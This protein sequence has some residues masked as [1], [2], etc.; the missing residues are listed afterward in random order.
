MP[1]STRS[2][3]EPYYHKQRKKWY[4]RGSYPQKAAEGKLYRK[5]GFRGTASDTR[6][7][8]QADCDRQNRE[9]EAEALSGE[10][11]PTFEQAALVYAN[12][13]RDSRYLTDKLLDEIG[14]VR[15]DG[16]TDGLMARV[17]GN[18]YPN[19]TSAT[20]NRQLYT[21]VISVLRLA[22]KGAKWKPSLARPSGYA[23][24]KPAKSPP[25]SWFSAVI[26]QCR[27]QLK[28]LLLCC[29]LHGLRGGILMR[30]APDAFNP[31]ARTLFVERDKKGDP[32][33]VKLAADAFEA[34]MAY[35][36]QEGP[37]L[38]GMLTW[39]NRRGAYRQLET[40]CKRAGV[41]YMP[42]HKAGRHA[43]AKR[44]LDSGKS[45]S[46]VRAAGRWSTTRMVVELYGHYEHSEVDDA[47]RVLGEEWM[48]T[49]P[50]ASKRNVIDFEPNSVTKRIR[51]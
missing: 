44:L 3:L 40:A 34:F 15:C 27:P 26:P 5:R 43:F 51:K 30:L 17:G 23:K 2:T 4:P 8:C 10:E 28:A 22:S 47:T 21:P 49:L 39:K 9:L 36:W 25:T 50:G 24:M 14:H 20:L 29:T 32:V 13:G 6:A 7:A 38:F 33:V 35:N 31:E 11:A 42:L 18:I 37:G 41:E 46:H 45:V 12:L 1:V 48:R 16:F 19:C